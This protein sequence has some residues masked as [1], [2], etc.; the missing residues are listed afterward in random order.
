LNESSAG[1]P[2]A[3]SLSLSLSLSLDS[4]HSEGIR[5]ELVSLDGSA[6]LPHHRWS[7]VHAIVI[8]WPVSNAEV[9]IHFQGFFLIL[10][11]HAH[12]ERMRRAP[13]LTSEGNKR[14][15]HLS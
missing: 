8:S 7:M 11:V 1:G 6:P 3:L 5:H 4:S 10:I 2:L 13:L 14:A 12:V 9:F 15:S